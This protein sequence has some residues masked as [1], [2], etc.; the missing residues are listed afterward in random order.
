MMLSQLLVHT[1]AQNAH[2]NYNSCLLE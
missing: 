1:M 2:S